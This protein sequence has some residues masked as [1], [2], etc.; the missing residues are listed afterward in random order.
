MN[1][2][3]HATATALAHAP[4]VAS[5]AESVSAKEREGTGPHRTTPNGVLRAVETSHQIVQKDSV[6]FAIGMVVI[7]KYLST[8]IL[9][10]VVREDLGPCHEW[11]GYRD[12][13]GYGLVRQVRASHLA[14][15]LDGREIPDGLHVCHRCDNPPCIRPDHLFAGTRSENMRDMVA[16]GRHRYVKGD[17]NHRTVLTDEQVREIRAR[18]TGAWGQQTALALEYGVTGQHVRA[19]LNGTRRGDVR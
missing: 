2:Q 19:I 1:A 15:K 14:V 5:S 12:P 4:A 7:E 10:R 13:Y 16:K 11:Q 18:Y 17:H 9:E 6:A 8:E 3:P